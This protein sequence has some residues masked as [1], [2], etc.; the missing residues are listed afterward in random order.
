M[1]WIRNAARDVP[2]QRVPR[3]VAGASGMVFSSS[4]RGPGASGGVG[5]GQPA[6]GSRQPRQPRPNPRH[7]PAAATRGNG[8]H[9][10]RYAVICTGFGCGWPRSQVIRSRRL[11]YP[12]WH[13]GDLARLCERA[14]I[15]HFEAI[16]D[17]LNTI[18]G[19][20]E[21]ACGAPSATGPQQ[22]CCTPAL[23]APTHGAANTSHT[24]SC[25]ATGRSRSRPHTP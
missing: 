17:A 12:A 20:S 2:V 13:P 24:T 5:P 23:P 11:R 9:H 18:S 4:A 22:R 6:C 19:R 21:R 16:V 14:L 15:D 3:G 1:P 25:G 8:Q 7:V 10:R